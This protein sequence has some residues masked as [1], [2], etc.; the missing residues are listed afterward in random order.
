MQPA[1]GPVTQGAIQWRTGA[2]VTTRQTGAE[3]AATIDTVTAGGNRHFVVQFDQPVDRRLRTRLETTGLELLSYLGDNAFFASLAAER[4]DLAALAEVDALMAALPIQRSWKLHPML[5]QGEVAAWAVVSGRKGAGREQAEVEEVR[6]DPDDNP[7]VAAYVVF[8]PDVALDPQGVRLCRARQARIVS[9]LRTINGLVIELPYANIAALADE[10]VVQWIQPPLPKFAELNDGNRAR[11][12]ADTVQDPPY[13]LDGSG[14][15]VMVYDG[16]FGLPSHQDF[17]GR[18]TVHDSSGLS[19]HATHVAG[20]I[21]GDGA[22]SLGTYRGMAPAVLLESYGFEQEGGLH[23]GFLYTDPGDLEADYDEAINVHAA[24]ISNNSIGS[25][26]EGNFFPCEWHGDY[27]VTASIIDAIVCGSLS[28]GEP[29]RIVWAGGNERPSLR[30]DDE[31]YGDYYSIAPPGGA[32]N[33]ITVAAL[34]SNDDSMTDFSSWGPTDDGRLKPDLAAPGCQSDDDLGITSCASDGGYTTKCGTSMA[35]PTVCGLGALLLQDYRAQSPGEPD[36]RNS[37]LKALLAHTA[38]DLGNAGPDYQYGYG[39]VRIQPAVDL[40]RAGNFL[41]AE[42]DQGTIYSAVV[43]AGPDDVELKVTLAWDDVPGTPNVDPA[44]VNDLDLC[45]FD[46]SGTRYFPWMLDR[47]NP[48]APAVRTQPDHVNN[49]EQVVVSDPLP[50]TYRVEVHGLN[51]PQGPQTFSLCGSPLLLDCSSQG[52][53]WLDRVKYA[54]DATATIQVVDCDLNTNGDEVETVDVTVFSDS[55]PAGETVTLTETAPDTAAFSGGIA[56]S[57]SDS[58]GVLWIAAG[59]TVTA[60]YIDAD[61]GLGG[62]DVEVTVTA[63]VDCQVPLISNV[64]VPDTG[65]RD[66]T[67]TFD[68]DEPANGAVHYGLTCESL[69]ET[70]AE[71]DWHTFHSIRLSGLNDDATYYFIVEVTD[72]AD[73]SATDDNGGLCYSFT[74]PVALDFFTESFAGNDNDLDN[75]SLVLTPDGS[76]DHYT[77]CIEQISTLP[78][79]PAGGTNIDLGDDSSLGISLEEGAQVSLYGVAYDS[80]FVGSNGYVTFTAPDG[81]PSETLSQHFSL[82]RISGLFDDLDPSAGGVVSWKQLPGRAAVTW[83]NVPEYGASNSNTFQIEMH[84]DGQ[85]RISWLTL[86]AED[87][88]AGVSAGEGLPPDFY[89]TDLSEAEPCPIPGDLDGDGDVDHADLGILLSDWGCDSG[90]CPGDCDGDGD[91]D[92]ADLGILLANWGYGT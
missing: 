42:V 25:N 66:A 23:E 37:T 57:T 7:T 77:A 83:E 62:T 50:G 71:F 33:H 9:K 63:V 30:C 3:I 29:F 17:G 53:I 90:N 59:D 52:V 38:V 55:E 43:V 15:T 85:L 10:D 86:A 79:D 76:A 61:D 34:N 84:F 88:I 75:L 16:G 41:E 32:K 54:C 13:G 56:L 40:M 24:D 67:I 2:M 89:E 78:T 51:L 8:H 4:L 64:Q 80:F 26:V 48:S 91:T 72:E 31:G 73:N 74:T 58:A 44:L 60:R 70:A 92:H 5:E 21:G 69:T 49:I 87:G 11:V 12:G 19:D 39:S 18:L 47:Y 6:Y 1:A 27:G 20:T 82:P 35:S 68:T 36:F 81:T 14:V 28:G 46:A 22:A 45:V 65:P